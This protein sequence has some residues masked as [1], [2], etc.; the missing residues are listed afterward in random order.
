M[1]FAQSALSLALATALTSFAL[2]GIGRAQATAT[3]SPERIALAQ[4]LLAAQGGSAALTASLNAVQKSMFDSLGQS[5]GQSGSLSP[6]ARQ[7]IIDG[8]H[9]VFADLMPKLQARVAAV[10]AADFDEKQLGDILAFYQSPTGRA[11]VAKLPD[12]ARQSSDEMAKS[13]PQLQL[14]VLDGLCSQTDCPQ[15]LQDRIAALKQSI[16]PGQSF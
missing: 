7:A 4:K 13:I 2:P 5:L 11:L 16:P 3:P 6:A 12:I 1:K 14:A 15:A 8:M 10:Y 9:K